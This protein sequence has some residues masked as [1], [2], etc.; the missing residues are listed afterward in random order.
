M[1]IQTTEI[2]DST[3]R[4][5]P[6]LPVIVSRWARRRAKRPFGAYQS[7]SETMR[8]PGASTEKLAIERE[9]AHLTNAIAAGGDLVPPQDALKTRQV[10][11][12]SSPPRSWRGSSFDVQGFDRKAI[13]AKVEEHVN[14]WRALLTKHV[15]DGR[16]LLREVLA[17]PLR[18]TPETRTYHFEGL[19]SGGC[20]LAWPLLQIW[21]RPQRDSNPCFGLERATSWASGRWGRS[22]EKTE[23]IPR[24]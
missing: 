5:R 20:S 3:S 1:R 8:R 13:Q 4:P 18:F 6:R 22:G 11:V 12:T 16:R 15:E 17:G 7:S 14:G 23:M 24:G 21:W 19:R 2:V 10:P 9:V